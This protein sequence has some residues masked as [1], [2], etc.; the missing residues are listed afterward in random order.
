MLYEIDTRRVVTGVIAG[1]GSLV[2]GFAA[3]SGSAF[4]LVLL[5]GAG[6]ALLVAVLFLWPAY[7]LLKA[8]GQLKIWWVLLLGAVVFALL[9][10]V[11]RL[12]FGT[13]YN[14][15]SSY[16]S[17]G[18]SLIENGRLTIEGWL[19]L[20]VTGPMYLMPFGAL[21]AF[22]GWIVAFGFCLEPAKLS[23]EAE[24]TSDE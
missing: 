22:I 24:S 18:V 15:G 8:G 3:L 6:L 7:K 19:T 1:E 21:A 12:F 16:Y 4:N 13:D 17:N 20:Y 5:V 14:E 10:Y 9:P 23:P 2:L 11:S